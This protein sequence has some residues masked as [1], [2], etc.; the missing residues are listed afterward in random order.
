M[1]KLKE[2]LVEEI[3]EVGVFLNVVEEVYKYIIVFNEKVKNIE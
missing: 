1:K 3:K 2:V